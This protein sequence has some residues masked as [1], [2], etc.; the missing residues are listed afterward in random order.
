MVPPKGDRAPHP[1]TRNLK[2]YTASFTGFSPLYRPVVSIT[3]HY[4]KAVSIFQVSSGMLQGT[5]PVFGTSVSSGC[6]W[7]T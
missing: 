5:G 4:L 7:Q 3:H 2:V 1:R 6:M